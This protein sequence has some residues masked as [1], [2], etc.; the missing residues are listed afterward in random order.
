MG[1]H[2]T[3]PVALAAARGEL[4]P[5]PPKRSKREVDRM[6]LAEIER[7]TGLSQIYDQFPTMRKYMNEYGY[8]GL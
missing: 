3:N 4:P 6:I 8:R 2:K 7:M 1:Q 5:R